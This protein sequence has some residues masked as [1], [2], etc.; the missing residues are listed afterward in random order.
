MLQFGLPL[1]IEELCWPDALTWEP[2][3]QRKTKTYTLVLTDFRGQ[4]TFGYC[5]RI[6]AEGDDVCLPLA[7]CI[8]TRHCRARGLFS[9]VFEN[10]QFI[11]DSYN[12]F[13][14]P[15]GLD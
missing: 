1:R 11:Q 3:L 7:I 12:S 10:R 13:V 4:R 15:L 2:H 9:Q 6:Q 14:F 5:R 8:L